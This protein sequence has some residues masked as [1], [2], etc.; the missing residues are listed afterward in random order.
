[1]DCAGV[2]EPEE[3][4]D[5]R[6]LLARAPRE[7]SGRNGIP[8]LGLVATCARD[9]GRHLRPN[10]Y[11]CGRDVNVTHAS[12]HLASSLS[13]LYLSLAMVSLA[14]SADTVRC[15]PTDRALVELN[16]L[17]LQLVSLRLS[18]GASPS[19]WHAGGYVRLRRR[20][21]L[22]DIGRRNNLKPWISS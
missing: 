10:E 13:Q 17:P 16:C 12:S 21:V 22:R 5:T 8:E 20:A 4:G 2:R 19:P 3:D 1:M 15:S 6:P 18:A 11:D 14:Q 7:N 9:V